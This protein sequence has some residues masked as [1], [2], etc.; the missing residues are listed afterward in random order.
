MTYYKVIDRLLE[1][2]NY[3]EVEKKFIKNNLKRLH[4]VNNAL[5][6]HSTYIAIGTYNL[7]EMFKE[8]SD[9][10]IITAGLM[11]DIGKSFLP[12]ELF[13][14]DG[15]AFRSIP[16]EGHPIKKHPEL[17]YALLA[18][19]FPVA[20]IVSGYHH[21]YQDKSYFGSYPEEL[22]EVNGIKMEKDTLETG[23]ELSKW[24]SIVDFYEA[25]SRT[26]GRSDHKDPIEM[27]FEERMALKDRINSLLEKNLLNKELFVLKQ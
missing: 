6:T 10:T 17:G 13:D 16:P 5:L 8:F 19:I 12:K 21:K 22:K 20:A 4:D 24:V 7:K 25:C 11:H 23:I 2:G 27:L 3:G 18:K 1:I 26:N 9:N 15:K 14:A